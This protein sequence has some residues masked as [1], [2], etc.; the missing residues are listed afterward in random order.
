MTETTDR[1][2]TN[3]GTK[4][5]PGDKFCVQCGAKLK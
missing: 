2:C 4:V 3:C 1:F 5:K